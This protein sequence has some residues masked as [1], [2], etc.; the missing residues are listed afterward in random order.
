M[1]TIIKKLQDLRACDDGIEYLD[2][3]N[4]YQAA[5]DNCKRG[6]WML[7]VL[8]KKI[9]LAD[10]S[11]LRALT[12][13]KARCAKLVIHLMKDERSKKAVEIAEA[14]GNGEATREELDAAAYAAAAAAAAAYAVYAVAAAAAAAAYA[15]AAAADADAAA[16]AA[17]AY[18]AYAAA[19][20]KK[21]LAQCAGIIRE[22][23][24]N[25]PEL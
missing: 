4:N 5:W 11:Q 9:D 22:I 16:Y 25:P 19:A 20:R 17:A 14:F 10:E 7:W 23:F 8:R 1:K 24:P 3:Q 15:A 2:T 18:A 21:V 6:D 13:A 12:L